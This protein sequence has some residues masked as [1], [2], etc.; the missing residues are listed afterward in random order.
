MSI[1]IHDTDI[2]A[3]INSCFS[4]ATK[5]NKYFYQIAFLET[6]KTF[7]VLPGGLKITNVPFI[8]FVMGNNKISWHNTTTST[9]K[10]LLET[11]I[12][13]IEGKRIWLEERFWDELS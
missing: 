11:L 12:L 13:G 1:E 2:A 7:S 10:D 6:C 5:C 8:S 3:G 4:Y 9:E